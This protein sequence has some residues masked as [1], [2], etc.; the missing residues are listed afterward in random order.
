M[1]TYNGEF[2]QND[3]S[4]GGHFRDGA[5]EQAQTLSQQQGVLPT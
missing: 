3:Q 5:V 4:Q 2:R 1:Q